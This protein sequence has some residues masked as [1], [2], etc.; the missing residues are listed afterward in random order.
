[1]I[2]EYSNLNNGYPLIKSFKLMVHE[3]DRREA[4]LLC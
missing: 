4:L 1:M 2:L 3:D